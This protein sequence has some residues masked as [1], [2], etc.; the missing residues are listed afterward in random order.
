MGRRDRRYDGFGRAFFGRKGL[1]APGRNEKSAGHD[2]GQ[3]GSLGAAKKH[4]VNPQRFDVSCFAAAAFFVKS[5]T[6]QSAPGTP[7]RAC[8]APVFAECEADD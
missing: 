2:A 1:G 6:I 5:R 4:A 8:L 7:K 3:K